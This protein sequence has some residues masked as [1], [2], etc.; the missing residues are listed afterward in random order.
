MASAVRTR[1]VIDKG[2]WNSNRTAIDLEL[3]F[4]GLV[5]DIGDFEFY[6]V[7]GFGECFLW[8]VINS[9]KA[10]GMVHVR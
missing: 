10:I 7:P 3:C 5:H 6:D 9:F 1:D 8:A 4:V 2:K